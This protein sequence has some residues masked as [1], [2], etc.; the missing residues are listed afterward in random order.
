[1]SPDPRPRPATIIGELLASQPDAASLLA[2][3]SHCV[4]LAACSAACTRRRA[5]ALQAACLTCEQLRRRLRPRGGHTVHFVV[6]T[7]L[8]IVLGAGL[9]TLDVIELGGPRSVPLALAAAAVWLTVAWL[10]A[11]AVRQQRWAAVAGLSVVAVMLGLL[12]VALHGLG[13]HPGWPASG[14][15]LGNTILAVLAG[16]FILVLVI[17]ATMLMI[18]MEPAGLLMARRRW[19]QAQAAYEEAAETEQADAEAVAVAGEAWLGLVRARVTA[20][21]ADDE[22]LVRATVG[23]AA[24]LMESIR[25]KLPPP[26]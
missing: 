24:V 12:L 19:H 14:Y 11:I 16:T 3:A 8:V 6:G 23:L 18:H 2:E 10:A 4:A 7:L 9:V 25:P 26:L 20:V 17:G 1:V 5:A 21:A 13:P 22:S 15:A